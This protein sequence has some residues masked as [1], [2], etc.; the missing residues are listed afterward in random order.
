M[1]QKEGRLTVSVIIPVYNDPD[2]IETTLNS[3]TDQEY[4]ES[5]YEVLV[6]DNGSTD[7]TPTVIESFAEEH[8]SVVALSETEIQGSYAA[9][10][11]GIECASGDLL[12]FVDAD[13]W[14]ESDWIESIVRV[15]KEEEYDYFGCNVEIVPVNQPPTL[16]ERYNMTTG[17]PV[18]E[19]VEENRF[20]P[21]C[22]L[23]VWRE[24][25]EVVG[26]FNERLIS[27]GDK[28][29]GKRVHRNGFSQGFIFKLIMYHP[30]RDSFSALRRKAF[31]VGRG[32]AQLARFYRERDYKKENLL[33]I[34]NYAPPLPHK[35]YNRH[36]NKD[37]NDFELII[38][39]FHVYI[40]IL[41]STIGQTYEAVFSR[42]RMWT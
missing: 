20:A 15:A 3:L 37:F 30:A 18:K 36:K 32:R 38:I 1:T 24:V 34:K 27:G 41:S 9:R 17:F 8:S 23:V 4:P 16:A 22:C 42:V 29:F 11:C 10:N 26:S 40:L 33:N 12:A 31:R 28:E 13:M 25:V 19:Y 35:F 7:E 21:T 5:E 2:G 14:V 6:V 39:Y